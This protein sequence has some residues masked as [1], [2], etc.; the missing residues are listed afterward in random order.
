MQPFVQPAAH[1]AELPVNRCFRGVQQLGGLF[2]GK[3]E[4]ETQF[5][6]AAFPRVQLVK[7]KQ[8]PIEVHP[9]H[10]AS[11]DPGQ[12]LFERHSDSTLSLL[13]IL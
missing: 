6:H 9:L 11:V 10:V 7:L 5:N 2:G 1:E 4:K 8:D 13:P 12:V 3:P